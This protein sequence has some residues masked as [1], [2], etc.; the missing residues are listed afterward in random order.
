M[1]KRRK[2]QMTVSGSYTTHAAGAAELTLAYEH[3]TSFSKNI[4]K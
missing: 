1:K 3:R 4:Y 2:R